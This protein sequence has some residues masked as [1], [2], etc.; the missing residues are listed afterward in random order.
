MTNNIHIFLNFKQREAHAELR[1]MRCSIS[2]K[3]HYTT[4][5]SETIRDDLLGRE[6]ACLGSGRCPSRVR[7]G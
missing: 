4:F 5:L 7:G 3:I 1:Q 6:T 2:R